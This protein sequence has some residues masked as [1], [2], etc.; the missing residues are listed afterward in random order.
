MPGDQPMV[1]S[2]IRGCPT[3]D[4]AAQQTDEKDLHMSL[5]GKVALVT[6]STSGIGLGIAGAL[7]AEGA[8]IMLNGFGDANEIEKL[9][10]DLAKE[11]SVKV[12]YDGADLRKP[13]QVAAIV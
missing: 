11:F 6:G 7:A 4:I 1:R 13:D 5:K 9:R 10:G 8:S 12:A 3:Y 2:L